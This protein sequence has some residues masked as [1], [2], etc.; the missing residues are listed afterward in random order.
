M[1]NS[2]EDAIK[3]LLPLLHLFST[4]I[5]YFSKVVIFIKGKDTLPL[6][7]KNSRIS[8]LLG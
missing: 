2:S 5:D 6:G 7:Q 4:V 3:A 1:A 8:Y